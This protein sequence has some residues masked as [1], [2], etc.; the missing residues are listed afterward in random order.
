MADTRISSTSGSRRLRAIWRR[1]LQSGGVDVDVD[2]WIVDAPSSGSSEP[3]AADVATTLVTELKNPAST[4]R[5]ASSAFETVDTRSVGVSEV[6]TTDDSTPPA[7]TVIIPPDNSV[8]RKDGKSSV[9]VVVGAVA[10]VVI[11][12]GWTGFFVWRRRQHRAKQRSARRSKAPDAG[13]EMGPAAQKGQDGPSGHV[14]VNNPLRNSRVGAQSSSR[15]A[16]TPT[17]ARTIAH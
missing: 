15:A 5:S 4:L 3:S 10:S 7:V 11:A 9:F 17:T 1:H 16:F 14:L 13:I 6:E 12:V 2:F 8:Q